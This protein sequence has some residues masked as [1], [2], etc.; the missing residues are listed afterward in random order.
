MPDEEVR[1]V[2]AGLADG[3][4]HPNEEKRRMARA[5]VDVYHGPEAGGRAEEAFDRVFKRHEVPAD[6]PEVAL[7]AD[8]AGQERIW[9]PRAL[10]ALGLASSNSE[11][12]RKMEEGAVRLDGQ[13]VADP[14]TE[15]A[16][17]ELVGR[18]L[19]VGRRAQV[20]IGPSGR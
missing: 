17:D 20:R 1:A 2:E 12:K 11:G 10:V 3:S 13:P 18:V 4:R 5:V 8:L 19:S 15:L 14:A 7:P 6:V 9:L 16:P